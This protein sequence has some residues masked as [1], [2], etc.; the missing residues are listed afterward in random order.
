MQ[1]GLLHCCPG[2]CFAFWG[3]WRGQGS[4]DLPGGLVTQLALAAI[5]CAPDDPGA[6]GESPGPTVAIIA[7]I[8]RADDYY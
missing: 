4:G 1:V 7:I 3:F 8:A 2:V 5:R 6:A